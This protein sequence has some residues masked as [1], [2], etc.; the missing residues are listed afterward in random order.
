LFRRLKI[1]LPHGADENR[2]GVSI[3]HG[4]FSLLRRRT[5]GHDRVDHIRKQSNYLARRLAMTSAVTFWAAPR[6]SFFH[7][8]AELSLE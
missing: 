1:L 8:P 7:G 4:A 5:R 6:A 3:G 2:G